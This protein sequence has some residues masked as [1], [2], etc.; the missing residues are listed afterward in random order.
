MTVYIVSPIQWIGQRQVGWFRM[1]S[2]IA[3][4]L[5][6]MDRGPL[7]KYPVLIALDEFPA[8]GKVEGSAPPAAIS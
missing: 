3:L 4:N 7:P 1:L 6:V 8:L 2:V 5:L